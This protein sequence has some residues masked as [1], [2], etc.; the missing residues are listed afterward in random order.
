[1]LPGAFCLLCLYRA[2]NSTV[3]ACSWNSR[4]SLVMINVNCS[5][6]DVLLHKYTVPSKR[7]P[8]RLKHRLDL[9]TRL[10]A[11]VPIPKNNALQAVYPVRET[12]TQNG[13]PA[14]VFAYVL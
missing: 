7:H 12:F 4:V 6:D 9:M 14:V 8:I 13:V 3:L 5:K 1:M 11:R 2:L 10:I